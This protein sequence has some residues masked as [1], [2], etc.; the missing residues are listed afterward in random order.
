MNLQG[1][2]VS[3]IQT[4]FRIS[5]R[6]IRLPPKEGDDGS[7]DALSPNG[8]CCGGPTDG[9][10]IVWWYEPI[11]TK[12]SGIHVDWANWKTTFDAVRGSAREMWEYYHEYFHHLVDAFKHLHGLR[13]HNM[14]EQYSRIWTAELKN[15]DGLLL[16]E[17]LAETYAQNMLPG[18]RR[19]VSHPSYQ[20]TLG[21]WEYLSLRHVYQIMNDD[22]E[23]FMSPM[24]SLVDD[25]QLVGNLCSD[26][27]QYEGPFFTAAH[28]FV[29]GKNAFDCARHPPSEL[30][31]FVH[32]CSED[33][34]VEVLDFV[35]RNNLASPKFNIE[36]RGGGL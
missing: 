30:P 8:N 11:G 17:A 26:Y 14:A 23:I 9:R 7:V 27:E 4:G 19:E 25:R 12:H 34:F 28:G 10:P 36:K 29:R 18:V 3:N 2:I 35:D 1:R 22:Y 33:W 21:S 24:P 6:M 31:F 13:T 20:Q 32:N 15:G 16:G 5:S